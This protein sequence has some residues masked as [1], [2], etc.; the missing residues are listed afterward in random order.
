MAQ[1]LDESSDSP[2][3][4]AFDLADRA[5][6]TL[7][8]GEY[9]LRVNGKGRVG[10]TYRFAVN[11]GERQSHAISLDEGQLLGGEPEPPRPMEKTERFVPIPFAPVTAAAALEGAKVDFIQW[12]DGSLVRRDGAR[13]K[14][15]WDAFHPASAFGRERDPAQWF[16][17]KT[18][19]EQSP[20]DLM[21]TAPDVNGD[22]TNDLVWYFREKAMFFALSGKDGALLWHHAELEKPRGVVRVGRGSGSA[23]ARAISPASRR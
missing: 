5:V 22:G 13:G 9:R 2:I 20:V 1:V 12:S 17:S 18:P 16:P 23:G 3:G 7:P 8:E 11:R 21:E 6:L 10:R 19:D 15:I 14:V 4:E